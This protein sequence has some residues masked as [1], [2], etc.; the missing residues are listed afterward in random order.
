MSAGIVTLSKSIHQHQSHGPGVFE[1]C[2]LTFFI[3]NYVVTGKVQRNAGEGRCADGQLG[4]FVSIGHCPVLASL[5]GWRRPGVT[6]VNREL[7]AEARAIAGLKG[8][9]INLKACPDGTPI[10]AELVIGA[11]HPLFGIEKSFEMTSK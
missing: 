3:S 8:Y 10:R 9:V 11:C 6:S 7:E 1:L 5:G 4:R 2:G